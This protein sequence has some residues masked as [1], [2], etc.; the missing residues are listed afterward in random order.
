M[1]PLANPAAETS[2]PVCHESAMTLVPGAGRGTRS[3]AAGE[4]P[5]IGGGLGAPCAGLARGAG[6]GKSVCA[7]AVERRR[8]GAPR[9]G[10]GPVAR[11]V[12]PAPARQTDLAAGRAVVRF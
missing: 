7:A 11:N 12:E 9:V 8:V 2:T 10:V 1:Q 3:P 5:S 6:A 4:G